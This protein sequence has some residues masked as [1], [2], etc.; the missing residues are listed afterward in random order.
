LLDVC[1]L[2]NSIFANKTESI[3][4]F[5]GG[6]DNLDC[7]ILIIT[8]VPLDSE[9]LADTNDLDSKGV[10]YLPKNPVRGDDHEP[11]TFMGCVIAFNL[12]QDFFQWFNCLY[13]F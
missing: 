6:I 5:G 2:F 13:H 12:E 8:R 9:L 7:P 11:V 10:F 3:G 1:R 4:L